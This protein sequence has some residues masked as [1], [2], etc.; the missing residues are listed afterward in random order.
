MHQNSAISF[1]VIGTTQ[2]LISFCIERIKVVTFDL[3][4]RSLRA[5]LFKF[6]F[7]CREVCDL[8]GYVI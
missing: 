7:C 2:Y 3:D 5:A 6:Y 8:L 1:Q 4:L